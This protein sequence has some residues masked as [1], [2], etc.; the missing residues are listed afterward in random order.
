MVTT[1][2]ARWSEV[3][4]TKLS[5]CESVLWQQLPWHEVNKTFRLKGTENKN[6]RTEALIN[7]GEV[8]ASCIVI[9]SGEKWN[10]NGE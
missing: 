7:T 4:K 10:Y 8:V 6:K 2:E 9:A 5:L 1:N 3:R